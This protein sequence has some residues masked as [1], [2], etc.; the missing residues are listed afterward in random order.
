M[1]DTTSHTETTSRWAFLGTLPFAAGLLVLIN[2]V[3]IGLVAFG[4]ITDYDTNY[5][6][7]KGV[8]SMD[9]I[10]F[11]D[12]SHAGQGLDPDVMWRSISGGFWWNAGYIMV[13]VW[14]TLA[15]IVL[16]IASF[17]FLKA[18]RFD[19]GFDQARRWGSAG[20]LMIVALF[21]G[22]FIT[23]GGEWFQMWRS[24]VW[25]G[26]EAALRNALIAGMGIILIHIASPAWKKGGQGSVS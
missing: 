1:T 18:F 13:I 7:V 26:E 11:Q 2:A 3:Y 19:T 16:F 21:A 22:G 10:N 23:I 12:A 15:A 4:N 25:N 14:E 20:L 9:T 24:I 5:E 17:H 6:F 8:L